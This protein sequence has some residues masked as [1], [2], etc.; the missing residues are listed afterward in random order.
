MKPINIT[1]NISGLNKTQLGDLMNI[2][3]HSEQ[4]NYSDQYLVMHDY[5]AYI[6]G[7]MNSN[8]ETEYKAK[9]LQ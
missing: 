4:P 7:W 8:Q 5:E 1:V 2:L 6:S 9:Y 3:Y